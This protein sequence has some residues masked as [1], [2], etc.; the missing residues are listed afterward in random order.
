MSG[1]NARAQLL[2]SVIGKSTRLMEKW[3]FKGSHTHIHTH[4]HTHTTGNLSVGRL[5]KVTIPICIHTLGS[6]ETRFS[7]MMKLINKLMLVNVKEQ[8]FPAPVKYHKLNGTCYMSKW[9]S[10][11]PPLFSFSSH[12]FR[13]FSA[14]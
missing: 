8:N 11:I 10:K 5:Q 2:T 13:F 14:C 6:M 3:T 7:G 1:S 12:L 4:T 9:A